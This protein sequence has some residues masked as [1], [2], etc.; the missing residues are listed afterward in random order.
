[1]SDVES[2]VV[3]PATL[4][5]CVGCAVPFVSGD[6]PAVMTFSRCPLS[7]HVY[8]SVAH[9]A[10]QTKRTDVIDKLASAIVNTNL[11]SQWSA[12]THLQHPSVVKAFQLLRSRWAYSQAGQSLDRFT[13]STS[14]EEQ[15]KFRIDQVGASNNEAT[16]PAA[17]IE[18]FT[19]IV[20]LLMTIS[21][22]GDRATPTRP[23]LW[24]SP[25]TMPFDEFK[26]LFT[27]TY[28]SEFKSVPK[29][30]ANLTESMRVIR[31][32]LKSLQITLPSM[33]SNTEGRYWLQEARP[34]EH[35]IVCIVSPSES[36]LRSLYDKYIVNPPAGSRMSWFYWQSHIDQKDAYKIAM[37]T[38]QD[39]FSYVVDTVR[40]F[41][42]SKFK[43]QQDN[44]IEIVSSRIATMPVS[45]INIDFNIRT[46][47]I[48]YKCN[49]VSHQSW[50]V[51]PPVDGDDADADARP[52]MYQCDERIL[53]SHLSDEWL[54]FGAL[55]VIYTHAR[56][57]H[58]Y[59]SFPFAHV[60]FDA[61]GVRL[62]VTV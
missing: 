9:V 30:S 40:M 57:K 17:S 8:S 18:P 62:H 27:F 29:Q 26:L 16:A 15:S 37:R 7:A 43:C 60:K 13:Y 3:E 34:Y 55:P 10:C 53:Q 42:R 46:P 28:T 1:M 19:L 52:F 20:P 25:L 45:R 54:S 59:K 50:W 11:P 14:P 32:Q 41:I 2:S 21:E 35:H 61:P 23:Q 44:P 58:V 22:S 31:D 24:I 4:T 48:R 39:V 51:F 6:A 49:A 36:A 12:V 5:S 47:C 56:F 38:C 33:Y